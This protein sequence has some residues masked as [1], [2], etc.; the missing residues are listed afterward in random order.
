[1][2][3]RFE[4]EVE[5]LRVSLQASVDALKEIDRSPS[6]LTRYGKGLRDAYEEVIGRLD[7]ILEGVNT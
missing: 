1:M 7:R 3:S 6:G 5:T 2:K 4:Y